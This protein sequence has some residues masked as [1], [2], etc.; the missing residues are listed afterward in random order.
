M[1]FE[2]HFTATTCNYFRAS[3]KRIHQSYHLWG[4]YWMS[5]MSYCFHSYFNWSAGQSHSLSN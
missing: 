5:R 2:G 1:T 3:I 4:Y